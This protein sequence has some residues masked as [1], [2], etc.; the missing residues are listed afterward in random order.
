MNQFIMS[1]STPSFPPRHSF[2]P[3]PHEPNRTMRAMSSN[4]LPM[5]AISSLVLL[6]SAARSIS[7]HRFLSLMEPRRKKTCRSTLISSSLFLN[8]KKGNDARRSQTP[9]KCA[10]TNQ[11]PRPSTP[12]T[13]LTTSNS[14]LATVLNYPAALT[15]IRHAMPYS[16]TLT[17]SSETQLGKEKSGDVNTG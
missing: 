14:R 10:A 11:C 15:P 17:P 6:F 2:L 7:S 8:R 13:Q 1:P 5:P 16:G 12:L 3:V 9:C 4:P